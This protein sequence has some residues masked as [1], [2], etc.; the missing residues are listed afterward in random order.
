MCV[1]YG[2]IRK[3][4]CRHRRKEEDGKKR[5]PSSPRS[6]MPQSWKSDIVRKEVGASAVL[7]LRHRRCVVVFRFRA[8]ITPR[9][10]TLARDARFFRVISTASLWGLCLWHKWGDIMRACVRTG[11]TGFNVFSSRTQC[12]VLFIVFVTGVFAWGTCR[13]VQGWRLIAAS[14]TDQAQ[15]WEDWRRGD[16]HLTVMEALLYIQHSHFVHYNGVM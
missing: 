13:P 11:L 7:S 14:L 12:N 1:P 8:I 6:T 2:Q 15:C 4:K 5:S 16:N 3:R 9:R 10:R